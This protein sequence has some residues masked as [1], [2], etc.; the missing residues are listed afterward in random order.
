MLNFR[1]EY[2]GK[3]EAIFENTSACY[4]EAEMG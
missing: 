1:L 3:I 2:L 4:S